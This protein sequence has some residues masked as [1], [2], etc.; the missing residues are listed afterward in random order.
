MQ[1]APHVLT[2]GAKKTNPFSVRIRQTLPALFPLMGGG[3]SV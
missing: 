1:P 2:G 3:G